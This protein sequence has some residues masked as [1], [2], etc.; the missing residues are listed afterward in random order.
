M[1]RKY[2]HLTPSEISHFLEHGWLR[3]PSA[4]KPQYI[5]TWM[6]DF[7]VR[8]GWDPADPSTWT[9]PY[10]KMPRH[11]EVR[12]EEFCPEAWAKMC[13][14]VGGEELVDEVR[15]RWYVEVL[16]QRRALNALI[17]YRY[18]DQFIV[19][20]GGDE[21]WGRKAEIEKEGTVE[22]YRA[23]KGWHTDNDW[24]RFFLDSSGNALTIICC[25][26]DIPARGGGTALA[27]DGIAGIC[28]TLYAHPEG[29]DPPYDN[30]PIHA[31]VSTS[32]NQFTQI[33]GAKAGDIYV[34]HGL[35]PHAATPNHLPYVRVITNPHVNLKAPWNLNRADSDYTLCEQVILRALGRTSIP[36]YV[37]TR[38]RLATYPR[39]AYFKRDRV[40]LEVERLVAAAKAKGLGPESVD[41]VYLRGVEAVLEH[42]RRNGYD[43]PWGVNGVQKVMG[44]EERYMPRGER[45]ELL[46]E[47]RG[48]VLVA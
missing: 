25:F 29:L 24:Y 21:R 23:M 1:P 14:I 42:E 31:H 34:T 41:S 12:C 3:V 6:S 11:R 46:G 39:T 38:P 18:G 28:S 2:T 45:Q 44:S 22:D 35:L 19:S 20:A 17:P 4:I 26:T 32:C 16:E 36:E 15:E 37:P 43:R 48:G 47:E 27:E 10:L 8:I 5:S 7:W 40:P 30:I 33:S 13:E 9:E